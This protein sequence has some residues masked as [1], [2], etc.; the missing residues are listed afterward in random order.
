MSSSVQFERSV[1]VVDD[2]VECATSLARMLGRLG[3]CVDVAWGA[4]EA[5]DGL[6]HS[7]GVLEVE[8]AGDCGVT[9]A[10][11]LLA[12]GRVNHVVFFTKSRDAP[13]LAAARAAAPVFSKLE[14][15]EPLIRMLR[16]LCCE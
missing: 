2:D 14:G 6:E 11:D 16:A 12:S 3:F 5:R 13:A 7:V 10:F 4:A 15:A 8:L 9:L 1:L